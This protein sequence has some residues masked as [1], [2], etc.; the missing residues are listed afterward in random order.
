MS[1]IDAINCIK[2]EFLKLKSGEHIVVSR[3]VMLEAWPCR[4]MN[5]IENLSLAFGELR[6]E[7]I[8]SPEHQASRHLN[9]DVKYIEKDV[10]YAIHRR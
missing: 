3:Y 8:E 9:A 5:D 7:P 1:R 6:P 10:V 2:S 4:G